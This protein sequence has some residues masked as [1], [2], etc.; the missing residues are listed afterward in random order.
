[1][2]ESAIEKA[3]CDFARANGCLVYKMSGTNQK[4][5]PDR[6]ILKNGKTIFLEIKAPNKQPTAL[7]YRALR[8]LEAQ[9][10]FATWV[11]NA[12]MGIYWI[13]EKLLGYE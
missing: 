8:L 4:G 6:Q 11:D 2:R 13:K 5:Q 1:M 10:F 3:V 9:G 12:S 7:Q